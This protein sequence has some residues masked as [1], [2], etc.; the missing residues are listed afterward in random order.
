MSQ[1]LIKVQ[2]RSCLILTC[3]TSLKW[4]QMPQMQISTQSFCKRDARSLMI[5]IIYET[6]DLHLLSIITTPLS[7]KC[8][9][10]CTLYRRG[11]AILRVQVLWSP[12]TILL[13]PTSRRN[14]RSLGVKHDGRKILSGVTITWSYKSAENTWLILSADSLSGWSQCLHQCQTR[15]AGML[16]QWRS[17]LTGLRWLA[18]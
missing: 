16:P 5:N 15:T 13:R 9:L 10:L 17:L 8:S 3:L 18:L 4:S 12:P 7:K 1:L 11:A 2:L 14:P 6:E